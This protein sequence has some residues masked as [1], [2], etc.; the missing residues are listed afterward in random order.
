MSVDETRLNEFV[1]K[2]LGDMGAAMSSALV[3]TGDRLGLFREM[4]RSGPL[5]SATL[6]Q[7]NGTNE[8]YVREWLAAMAAA[9]YVFHDPAQGTYGL[10][11]EQAMVFA[12]K[13][14]TMPPLRGR[15]EAPAVP[16]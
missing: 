14:P 3:V 13:C 11:P 2:M 6:A 1:G 16:V 5:T 12:C 9:G 7:T 10:T 15:F 8:R 4:A